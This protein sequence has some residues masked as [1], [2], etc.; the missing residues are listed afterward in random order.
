M[1]PNGQ[2]L[3]WGDRIH[4]QAFDQ[5]GNAQDLWALSLGERTH[6]PW[7]IYAMSM[8]LALL[9]LP[10]I[11]SVSLSDDIF[12]AGRAS[13]SRQMLR[14]GFLAA[15][16]LLL[17]GIFFIV[18]LDLIYVGRPGYQEAAS[19]VHLLLTLGMSLAGMGWAVAD[20]RQRCPVCLRRVTH[21]ARVGLASRTFLTWNGTELMCA[22]GHTLLEI[23][24][25]PTSWF[26]APRWV[27]LDD[28]WEYLYAA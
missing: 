27:Y 5:E 23:P 21:P 12:V 10:A 14:W 4:I 13:A 17:V 2:E 26:G 28:S 9:A 19:G 7:G 3:M 16:F 8:L 20:Q 25:M 15:K 11:A 6:G 1:K 24:S 18:P 22:G